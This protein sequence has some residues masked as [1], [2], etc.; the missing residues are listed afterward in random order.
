MAKNARIEGETK[1]VNREENK[2][3]SRKSD[4]R[5]INEEISSAREK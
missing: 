3:I 4:Y 2:F 5:A 1:P